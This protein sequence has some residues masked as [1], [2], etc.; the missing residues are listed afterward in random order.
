MT[1]SLE[2]VFVLF[3]TY[4][5]IPHMDITE[6]EV[7]IAA[8]QQLFDEKEAERQKYLK[9]AEEC[10]IEVTQL[11]GEFRV[12]NRLLEEINKRVDPNTITVQP[13]EESN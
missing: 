4:A 10:F 12:L 13:E 9:L 11:Q 8:T 2:A 7:R 3:A 6:L 5:I 1:A